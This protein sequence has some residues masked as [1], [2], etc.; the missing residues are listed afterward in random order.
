MCG[1]LFS[2]MC[3]LLNRHTEAKEGRL[4]EVPPEA[5]TPQ[6]RPQWPQQQGPYQDS[7]GAIVGCCPLE[8]PHLTPTAA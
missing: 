7:V 4:A 3:L 1:D 5:P 6:I 8:G 2:V